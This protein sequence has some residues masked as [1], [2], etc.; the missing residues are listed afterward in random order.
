MTIAFLFP[1]QGS[2]SMGMMD[3]FAN[4]TVVKDTFKEASSILQQDMWELAHTGSEEQ[5]ELTTNTQP[6]MLISDVAMYRAWIK[7][8][9]KLPSILA[10]HS[11][12]EY[13]ALVASGALDFADAVS[14][15][16][17]RSVLMQN[18]VPSGVGAMAAVLGLTDENISLACQNAAIDG[19]VAEPA[20][21]NSPGQVVIA[22][23]KQT[24]E[25]AIEEA[26]KLGAKR[27][28]LIAM[29]TPSHCSLIKPAADLFA[30][31]LDTVSI[32]SANIPVVHNENVQESSTAQDIK[33]CLYQQLFKPVRWVETI[34]YIVAKDIRIGCECGPGKVI[35][36][37]NK[38]IDKEFQTI[39]LASPKDMELAMNEFSEG[40]I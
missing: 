21:Y 16:R 40:Q 20:N 10:G 24:V 33:K 32:E 34:R 28:M 18:A 8:G 30:S 25:K 36:G 4:V 15:V 19:G 38:R 37:L 23:D 17:Q 22:G 14:L 9:G 11:L 6:L 35:T 29:S 27:A 5:L 12:G 31:I 2:Q 3:A 26:K 7:L 39:S 13:A 1:G